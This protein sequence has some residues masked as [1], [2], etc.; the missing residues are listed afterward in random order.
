MKK[1]KLIFFGIFLVVITASIAIIGGKAFDISRN[2]YVNTVIFQPADLS[3]DRIEKPIPLDVL[4][5]EFIRDNL[6]KKFVHEYF[7]I[8]P[9]SGDMQRRKKFDSTLAK[10]SIP[11]VFKEW[12][13]KITAD[14]DKL[15]DKNIMRRVVVNN[16]ALP[17]GSEYFQ[18]HYDLLTWDIANDIMAAPQVQK[19]K[20]MFIRLDFEKGVRPKQPNGANF[21]VKK[22]LSGGSD[23]A[24]IFK[25][26]VL[27]V[28][29]K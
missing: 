18:V 17:P 5:D 14:M 2:F 15:V 24:T 19:N 27:E 6:I 4:S 28:I 29:I 22:Y 9:D 8:V 1:I 23:P 26:R 25:F 12:N 20:T 13:D 3:R 16:I 21:D 7:Y 11:S 10:M